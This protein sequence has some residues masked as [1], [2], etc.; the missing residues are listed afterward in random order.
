[1]EDVTT[2]V[3]DRDL[4]R[5]PQKGLGKPKESFRVVL[6]GVHGTHWM[7]SRYVHA[8]LK[9]AGYEVHSVFFRETFEQVLHASP[10]EL[11]LCVRTIKELDP[12]VVG[13]NVTSMGY[14][15]CQQIVA[16]LRPKLTPGVP[17]VW[18]GTHCTLKWQQCLSDNKVVD[19]VCRGEGDDALLELLEALR[20]GEDAN[21]IPNMYVNLADGVIEN[22]PRPLYDNLD[23]LPQNDFEDDNKH[24]IIQGKVHHND[25]PIPLQKHT[26][27]I[28]TARGCPF[29][30]TFCGNSALADKGNG[31]GRY[32]RRRSVESV[33][34]ELKEELRKNP[35]IDFIYFWD[36][37]FT[38]YP[39]WVLDFA[40]AYK[41]EIGLPF[42]CYTHPEMITERI[43]N[44]LADAG[45]ERI[46]MG[47]ESGSY[48]VRSQIMNRWETDENIIEASR[49]QAGKGVMPTYDFILSAFETEEDKARGLELCLQ[50]EKPFKSQMHTMTYYPGYPITVKAL[51]DGLIG[52]DDVVGHVAQ[53]RRTQSL[54]A[55][56]LKRNA[57]MNYYLL[58]GKKWIP[59][60]VIRWMHDHK[61]HEKYPQALNRTVGAYRIPAKVAQL[62]GSYLRYF[63]HGHYRYMWILAKGYKSFVELHVKHIDTEEIYE[64]SEI[65][66]RYGAPML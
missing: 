27:Y 19:F 42:F 61:V 47:I 49:I 52:E 20:L 1:M 50:L 29:R 5:R 62:A 48:R 44:A 22:P 14:V 34:A 57:Y 38:A 43:F 18:G 58:C 35:K 9:R 66:D 15:E 30:C 46:T 53:R 36:D 40:K 55:E 45:L 64:V 33:M 39:K 60:G 23:E 65:S 56:D 17:I 16:R 28:N 37:V 25:N 41:E 11:D 59:N 13:F 8:L 21:H 26:Y 24:F 54:Y 3:T 7:P 6:V 31:K 10:A 32:L 2:T 12:D 63:K 4:A 51:A